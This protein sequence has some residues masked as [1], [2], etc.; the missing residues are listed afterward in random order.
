MAYAGWLDRLNQTHWS[1]KL[2]LCVLLLSC[3]GFAAVGLWIGLLPDAPKDVQILPQYASAPKTQT[4][5]PLNLPEPAAGQ[6]KVTLP[7]TLPEPKSKQTPL[8][9]SAE[10][11]QPQAQKPR[12]LLE[13]LT[14]DAAGLKLPVIAS[15]KTTSFEAY[16]ARFALP[17]DDERARIALIV[18]GVGLNTARS[19]N[20]LKA[21]PSS[22]SIAISPYAGTP[23][24]WADMG[25]D[26][27]RDILMMVP[28][29]PNSFPTVDPGPDTLM[30][31]APA[32]QTLQRFHNVLSKAQ[33]YIGIINDTGSRFTANQ[34]SVAPVLDDVAARGLMVVDARASAYSVLAPQAKRRG[35]PVAVNT[36]F[37]DSSLATNDIDRQLRDL[38]RTASTV[39]SAVG[40]L[41]DFPITLER[42]MAW[43]K[44][45]N[46]KEFVLTPISA[47]ANRQPIR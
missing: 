14:E 45:L 32:I 38:E 27:G 37:I 4:R 22:I 23:Q 10:T 34:I 5:I 13:K 12:A 36:R 9:G 2:L 29:E 28:M 26:Q 21:L 1:N 25:L 33:G 39:G 3:F 44:A 8:P 43:E 31:D 16:K 19:E 47:V 24:R 41:R 35:I 30:R 17:E 15:D 42:V 11:A 18:T 46:K 40:V 6:S 20:A 7:L